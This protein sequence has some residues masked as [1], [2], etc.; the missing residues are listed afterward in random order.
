VE[1][2]EL[3][4]YLLHIAQLLMGAYIG[5]LLKPNMIKLGKKVLLLGVGEWPYY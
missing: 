3:P 1:T 2:P 4:G 5:L